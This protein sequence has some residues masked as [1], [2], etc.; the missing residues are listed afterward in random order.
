[1]KNRKNGR[2]L[3]TSAFQQINAHQIT[4]T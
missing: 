3:S 2:S 1:M 4:S